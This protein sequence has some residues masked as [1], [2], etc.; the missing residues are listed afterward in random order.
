MNE[1]KERRDGGINPDE[2]G[3]AQPHEVDQP[4]KAPLRPD[5]GGTDKPYGTPDRPAP[6][7]PILPSTGTP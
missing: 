6:D 3:P 5:D 4:G 1:R 2:L 7:K